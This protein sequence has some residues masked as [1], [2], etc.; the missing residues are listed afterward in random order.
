MLVAPILVATLTLPTIGAPA[1]ARQT[2][3]RQAQT[4]A[5]TIAAPAARGE[6][7]QDTDTQIKKDPKWDGAV[8]GALAGGGAGLLA[9]FAFYGKGGGEWPDQGGFVFATSVMGS[10]IG[11]ATGLIID[12]VRK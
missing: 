8:K 5:L 9:G 10:A 7:R 12:L 2:L 11:A 6:G 3:T 4:H 1:P